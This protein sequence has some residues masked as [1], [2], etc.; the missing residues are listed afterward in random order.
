MIF[1]GQFII[2]VNSKVYSVTK[3]LHSNIRP[4]MIHMVL[5]VSYMPSIRDQVAETTTVFC[6]SRFGGVW[7]SVRLGTDQG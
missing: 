4:A 3:F 1:E 5:I 7:H 6:V 2:K